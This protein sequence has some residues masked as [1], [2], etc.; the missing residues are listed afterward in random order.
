MERGGGEEGRGKMECVRQVVGSEGLQ[1][2]LLI[3]QRYGLQPGTGV[4]LELETDGIR[5][6]PAA[7]GQEEIENRA[8]RYLLAYLGDAATIKV[9]RDDGDW[10]VSVYGADI[11][12]SLGRLVYSPAGELLL[13]RSTPVEDMHQR[14]IEVASAQ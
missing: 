8:L 6:L 1:I 5:I 13:D 12:D 7:P 11:A 4:V 9:E 10:H 2:P 14:A 3:I